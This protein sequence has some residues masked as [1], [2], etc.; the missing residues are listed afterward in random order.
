MDHKVIVINL[1][2]LFDAERLEYL[3]GIVSTFERDNRNE[4]SPHLIY[5]VLKQGAQNFPIYLPNH[6]FFNFFDHLLQSD[7][8]EI[9]K[10]IYYPK[11]TWYKNTVKPVTDRATRL[12]A[13][14]ILERYQVGEIDCP[15]LRRN[16]L[17]EI[18]NPTG[19]EDYVE[20]PVGLPPKIVPSRKANRLEFSAFR[21][22]FPA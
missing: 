1:R 10:M 7:S 8:C 15:T 9:Y 6:E 3:A 16:R 20:R 17:A 13:N 12:V 22:L 19:G 2:K 18:G 5:L 11:F 14:R 4:K 21:F